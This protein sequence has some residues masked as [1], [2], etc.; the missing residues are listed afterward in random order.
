MSVYDTLTPGSLTGGRVVAGTGTISPGGQVGEIG[1]IDQ[2]IAGAAAAGAQLFLV[3]PANCA[4]A[5][6]APADALDELRL[7]RAPT[8][9]SALT[10]L[11]TFADDPSADL[12]RCP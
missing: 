4:A 10:S 3:P 11:S 6:Q 1:G 8:L 5:L 7:V 2:K 12:P 9:H